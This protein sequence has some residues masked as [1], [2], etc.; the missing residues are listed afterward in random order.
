[1]VLTPLQEIFILLEDEKK[2]PLWRLARWGKQAR[3]V[4]GKLKNYGWAAKKMFNGET[5]YYITQKGEK[6]FDRILKNLKEAGKWD[7][8]WR[9]VMFNVPEKQ[10]DL[11]DRIRRSLTRLGLGILQP[12]VWISPKNIKNDVEAIRLKLNLKNTLKFFEVTRNQ[13]LD[14]TIIKKSWNLPDL[15]DSYKKFNFQATRILKVLDKDPNPRITAKKYIF[16]Y[17]LILQKDPILPWEF[18]QKDVLR[19]AANKLYLELREYV[20]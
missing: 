16:Q 12:S 2:V 6:E 5:H 7:G 17:A 9:L 19:Q 8:R 10:R 4:L 11:R 3:G 13:S 15:E 1:M 14:Q 20:V 18:R